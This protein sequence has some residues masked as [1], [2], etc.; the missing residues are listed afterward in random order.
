VERD[1]PALV[2]LGSSFHQR[3]TTNENSLDCR[4]CTDGSAK[5]RSLDERSVLAVT[6]NTTPTHTQIHTHTP[7]THT[8][9]ETCRPDKHKSSK[10]GATHTHTH[11][12]TQKSFLSVS[13]F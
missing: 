3:G 11:T 2:V 12:H 7:N 6:H 1:A 8:K 10:R 4:A 9:R 5:R 13:L